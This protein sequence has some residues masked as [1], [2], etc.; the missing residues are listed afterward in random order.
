MKWW[1]KQQQELVIPYEQQRAEKLA[2]LGSTLCRKRQEK[3]LTL[4]DI[5]AQTRIR[6]R[7][8]QAIEA[9]KLDEL[10]EPVYTQGFIRRYADAV[11]LNGREI[12]NSFPTGDR[13]QNIVKPIGSSLPATQLSTTH[14][15][16]IY[17]LV[18][19]GSV[20][21]LS[22]ILNNSEQ[23][24]NTQSATRPA[25]SSATKP[26]A[27]PAQKIKTISSTSPKPDKK[28]NKP[29][30]VGVTVKTESWIRVIADGKQL[31]EGLLP[32]GTQ[33]TWVANERLTMRVG[34]AGGVLVSHNEEEAKPLGQLGQVEE[35]T[36]GAN[37]R[38]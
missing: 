16:L 21:A 15:Y 2:Q 5:E 8:L 35:I 20:S 31:F 1:K 22:Q 13:Q 34:N 11:G 30:E 24:S 6:L 25:I 17:I 26:K 37:T 10:P 9:G 18:I 7:Y 28:T 29:V 32:Q 33:R 3:K 12:A 38:L 27:T 23:V 36:F 19:V 4:E 14:L